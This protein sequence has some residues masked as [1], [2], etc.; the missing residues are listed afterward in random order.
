M[1][2]EAIEGTKGTEALYVE[3]WGTGVRAFTRSYI[4]FQLSRAHCDVKK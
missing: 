2:T 4:T 1:D 3:P